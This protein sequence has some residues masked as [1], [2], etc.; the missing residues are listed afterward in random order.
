MNGVF[1]YLDFDVIKNNPKILCGYSDP[2]SLL[3]VVYERTGLVTF[4]GPNFKSLSC[5]D[6]DYGFRQVIK[7]F[8]E[9]KLSLREKND[10]FTT[11]NMGEA[12]RGFGSAGICVFSQI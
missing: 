9:E 6:N 8:F 11:I 5:Q 4:Y 3:D 12:E 10:E 2:T 1:D 7:R